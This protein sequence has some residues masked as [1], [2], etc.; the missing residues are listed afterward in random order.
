MILSWWWKATISSLD[1]HPCV[2]NYDLV[3]AALLNAEVS[4]AVAL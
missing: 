3:I 4:T 2:L 1:I